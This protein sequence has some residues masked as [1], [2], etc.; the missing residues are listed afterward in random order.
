MLIIVVIL[1]FLVY[2]LFY[3]IDSNKQESI[4]VQ[5][6]ENPF[7]DYVY[8]LIQKE[9]EPKYIK[10]EF[11]CKISGNKMD[12]ERMIF[13]IYDNDQNKIKKLLKRF[14]PFINKI[15]YQKV[16]QFVLS[17]ITAK[18]NTNITKISDKD[19]ILFI[20]LGKNTFKFY[21]DN[22]KTGN[23]KII[24]C[25]EINNNKI[26][27]KNYLHI[28]NTGQPDLAKKRLENIPP[29]IRQYLNYDENRILVKND[30]TV[31]IP[32]KNNVKIDD[33]PL[34]NKK[35]LNIYKKHKLILK[36]FQI[37]DDHS[38]FYLRVPKTDFFS[39]LYKD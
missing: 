14:I 5:V 36:W 16:E 22:L 4:I 33:I 27:I 31:D 21:V 35:D 10:L 37:G 13:M 3:W 1:L 18:R 8:Q 20:G 7:F 28:K 39:I 11:S 12:K 25:I 30:E 2:C 32:F 23:K 26:K 38:T 19:P 24:E 6:T 9:V 34:L 17:R 29:I 15:N